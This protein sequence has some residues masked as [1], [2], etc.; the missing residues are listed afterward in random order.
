M[1]ELSDTERRAL[2]EKARM[3]KAFLRKVHEACDGPEPV[4]QVRKV[5]TMYAKGS[6]AVK[7]SVIPRKER[8]DDTKTL[9]A[10]ARAVMRA[11]PTLTLSEAVQ[12]A[13]VQ[14]LHEQPQGRA[15]DETLSD[16]VAKRVAE[17]AEQEIVKSDRSQADAY[18]AVAE[19]H[20]GLM[21]LAYC[22]YGH[23]PVT[24]AVEELVKMAASNNQEN[25]Q[26][27]TALLMS[28]GDLA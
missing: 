28:L 21:S 5:A 18:R 1:A 12:K 13:S 9:L 3:A 11:E 25:A 24:V 27:A 8:R 17:L 10:K 16:A 26:H 23:L 20:P 2:I 6:Q 14:L 22:E 15:W 4:E 19:Q 7:R